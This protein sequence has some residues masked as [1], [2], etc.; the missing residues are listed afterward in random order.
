MEEL[1]TLE[2]L[3]DHIS[4]IIFSRNLKPFDF[5]MLDYFSEEM[6]PYIDVLG[7]LMIG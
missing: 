3:G 2:C 6:Q 5:S 4:S 1:A 7:S